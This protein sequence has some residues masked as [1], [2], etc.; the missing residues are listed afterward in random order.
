MEHAQRGPGS[1]RAQQSSVEI[2]TQHKFCRCGN[3]RSSG[4]VTVYGEGVRATAKP[5]SVKRA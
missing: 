1:P 5:T 2:F 4:W 3:D